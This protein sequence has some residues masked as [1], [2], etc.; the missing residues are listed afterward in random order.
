MPRL[1]CNEAKQLLELIR[2]DFGVLKGE[3]DYYS[4][5]GDQDALKNVEVQKELLESQVRGLRNE[6]GISLEQ[7]KEILGKEFLGPDAVEKTWGVKLEAKDIP[8]IPF[9]IEDLE[10]AKELNQFLILR[11]P[12]TMQKMGEILS[13]QKVF[14][15]TSWY[16]NEAFYT[17]ELSKPGWALV[18]KEPIPNSTNQNYIEQTQTICDYLDSEVFGNVDE[19]PELYQAAIMEFEAKK[20]HLEELMGTGWQ[21]CVKELSELQIT[22]LTRQSPADVIHDILVYNQNNDQRLLENVYTWTSVRSSVGNL[23]GV[24]VF[25]SDGLRVGSDD[26]DRS[27]DDLGVSFSRSQ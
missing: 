14:S 16:Q 17:T 4:A 11:I 21:A 5:T 3:L 7:A 19:M 10:R 26:P 15:D 12:L 1:S 20:Q 23:V 2:A 24:G 27:G 9:T 22:K 18:S 13:D 8:R 6:L 25:R